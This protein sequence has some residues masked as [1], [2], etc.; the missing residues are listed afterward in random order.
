MKYIFSFCIIMF[1]KTS[2]EKET[3]APLNLEGIWNSY[4]SDLV[5]LLEINKEK[6]SIELGCANAEI[7]TSVQLNAAGKGSYTGIFQQGRPVIPVNYNPKDDQRAAKFDLSYEGDILSI[8]IMDA[9][10]NASI[11][12]FQYKKGVAK[13][14]LKCL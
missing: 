1:L 3:T 8:K 11:G 14:I 13:N 5:S 2:C 4:P 10:T 9:K 7:P 6:A 12:D